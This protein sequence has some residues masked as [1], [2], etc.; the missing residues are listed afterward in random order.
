MN[1]TTSIIIN[2][3]CHQGMGWERWKGIRSSIKNLFPDACSLILEKGVSLTAFLDHQIA[4]GD[5]FLISAGGDG[6]IHHLINTLVKDHPD[7][8][9]NVR[10]GAIG[11]GSSNDFIK[12]V[13][14][15][16]GGIPLRVDTDNMIYHDLGKLEFRNVDG[17]YMT[18]YF[19]INTSMG[20]TAFGNHMF[21]HPGTWL[22]FLKKHSTP[23]AIIHT[24]LASLFLSENY[25]CRV[26]FDKM[27]IEKELTNLNILKLPHVSGK[28]RYSQ[29]IA[30]ND[31]KISL[32]LC[33]SMGPLRKLLALYQLANGRLSPGKFMT[34][35]RTDNLKIKS[36]KEFLFECDG[37]TFTSD[38]IEISVI[39]KAIKVAQN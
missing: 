34:T 17:N 30:P 13:R 16:A 5:N 19:I 25:K 10:I 35:C 21:N 24:A 31:G 29:T 20:V 37:E 6:T 22:A 1:C 18:E 33:H 14:T 9:N 7:R 27:V 2:P 28:F 23:L 32:N 4:Q 12:P 8:L 3:Y 11:L 15:S 39:P 38:R 36:D 26:E